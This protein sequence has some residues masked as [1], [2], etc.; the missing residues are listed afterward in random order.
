MKI[1]NALGRKEWMVAPTL[2]HFVD[3]NPMKPRSLSNG[4]FVGIR[5]RQNSCGVVVQRFTDRPDLDV[6]PWDSSCDTDQR[7]DFIIAYIIDMNIENSLES[8]IAKHKERRDSVYSQADFH[9]RIYGFAL[10][11]RIELG[12]PG[13]IHKELEDR[14]GIPRAVTT[15]NALELGWVRFSRRF[16]ALEMNC[17]PI[18]AASSTIHKLVEMYPSARYSLDIESNS[19][20][21]YEEFKEIDDLLT[22]VDSHFN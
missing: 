2:C 13:E 7:H 11:D 9:E 18:R 3:R 12:V 16:G 17:W 1:E 15:S 6:E 21:T 20:H 5:H 19:K 14:M 4:S 8:W 22:W 10:F